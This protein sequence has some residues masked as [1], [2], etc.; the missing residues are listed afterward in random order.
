MYRKKM[1]ADIRC[2]LEY[3]LKVFGGKWK[4]RV[5][6]VLNESL[7]DSTV[8]LKAPLA[9]NVRNRTGKQ[10]ILDEPAY[11]FKHAIPANGRE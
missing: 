10:I 7:T 9:V 2:P 5:I 6:C 1:E 8:N 3:G 11:S 4:S